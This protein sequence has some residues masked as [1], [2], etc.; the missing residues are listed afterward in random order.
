MKIYINK[1][2]RAYKGKEMLLDS[3]KREIKSIVEK[4]AIIVELVRKELKFYYRR[5]CKR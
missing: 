5:F 4:R 3:G 2:N 1:R